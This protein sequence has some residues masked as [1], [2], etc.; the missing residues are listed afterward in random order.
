M[1]VAEPAAYHAPVSLSAGAETRLAAERT[2]A[3]VPVTVVPLSEM[4]D[5]TRLVPSDFVTTF[6]PALLVIPDEPAVASVVQV[7]VVVHTEST[8]VSV[9]YHKSAGAVAEQVA[10][11]AVAP[12]LNL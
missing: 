2:V 10:G 8:L 4:E 9:R 6:A 12:P 3:S 7:L 5:A 1:V 11:G